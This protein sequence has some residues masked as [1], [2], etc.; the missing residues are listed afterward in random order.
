MNRSL[1]SHLRNTYGVMIALALVSVLVVLA[2]VAAIAQLGRVATEA[3]D[4]TR[5]YME[6]AQQAHG[7]VT[8]PE[9]QAFAAGN[10]HP[11][12]LLRV[13]APGAIY[14][15]DLGSGRIAKIKA[16]GDSVYP[17][18]E[19]AL[20]LGMHIPARFVVNDTQFTLYP[21][22]SVRGILEAAGGTFLVAVLLA[23]L[24]AFFIGDRMAED[25]M[26]PVRA[27]RDALR[28]YVDYSKTPQLLPEM[29]RDEFGD[30]LATYNR[31]LCAAH[32]AQ[33]ERDDA[34]ARTH[35][36]IADAGHQLR[37]PLTVLSGFVGILRR[38]Q[39]RHPDDGP[40]ILQKM[41]SQIAIMRKLV[42]RLMLLESWQSSDD[43]LCELTDIG[44]FITAIVE[45]MAAS[46]C[47]R[48]VHIHA[49]ADAKA[50]VDTSEL[51][52][53]VTN[54]VANALKYAPDSA[55]TVDVTAGDKQVYIGIA[56]DGPGI[57]SDT[58]PH[59]FDRFYRG[60]RRDVPGSG[61]GLAIAKIAVERALGTLTVES[62]PGKGARFTIALPR[63]VTAEAPASKPEVSLA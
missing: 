13:I 21:L 6:R 38:G 19:L 3:R 50:C 9:I 20:L 29:G 30:L 48:T 2:I 57:P 59:I 53:A 60:A 16:K 63:A 15:A 8:Q 62:E 12:W 34:E 51:T 47:D 1:R 22:S 52:Y 61:L 4:V 39:L 36:F 41:D 42:E 49:V 10:S 56:D 31:T 35:Q 5:V 46:H 27:L 43:T 25:T 11:G 28:D 32:K 54:I 45:P 17:N 40:K 37:T 24:L 55:I 44:K 26:R 7:V 58:L 23:V 18:T 14:D 33:Q